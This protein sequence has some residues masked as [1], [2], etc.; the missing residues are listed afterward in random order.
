MKVSVEEVAMLLGQRD[1]EIHFL[2]KVIA[3]LQEELV[4]LKPKP[5]Q[6]SAP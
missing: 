4:K 6:E 5:E 3:E 1:I 2:Q